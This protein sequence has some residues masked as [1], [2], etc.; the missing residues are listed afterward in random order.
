MESQILTEFNRTHEEL[1]KKLEYEPFPPNNSSTTKKELENLYEKENNRSP[2]RELDINKQLFIIPYIKQWPGLTSKDL[3]NIERFLSITL[4]PIIIKI[5]TQYNR[6][7][8]SFLSPGLNPSIK[9]PEHPSYPSGHSTQIFTIAFFAAEKYPFFANEYREK[10]EEYATNREFAGVHY[11]SDTIFGEKIA[12][13]IF[14]N[15]ENP[16]T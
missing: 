3:V 6:V 11:K 5:K 10:A 4:N 9:V 14:R 8:P 7:R 13:Y 12:K 16:L 1:I 15:S 2:E